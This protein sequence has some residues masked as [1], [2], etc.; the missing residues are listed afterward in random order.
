MK[1]NKK[2]NLLFN[3][4][5]VIAGL[6]FFCCL[7]LLFDSIK[8]KNREVEDPTERDQRVF[9]YELKHQAYNEIVGHY[10][11]DRLSDF[12]PQPGYEDSYRVSQYAHAAFMSAIYEAEQNE[13]K[14]K[15]NEATRESLK[16]ELGKYAYTADEIDE[17]IRKAL[18]K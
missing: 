11:T 12:D 4:L 8:Y 3:I 15:R 14:A 5:L 17:I 18:A 13:S 7:I 2:L 1:N 10:S 6:A 16:K 9:E